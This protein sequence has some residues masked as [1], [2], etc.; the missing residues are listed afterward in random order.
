MSPANGL[1]PWTFGH[2]A[3]LLRKC[4]ILLK[5]LNAVIKQADH[6]LLQLTLRLKKCAA[7][8]LLSST[9]YACI[10]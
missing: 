6:K 2:S 7:S 4:F 8:A 1:Q 3:S 10:R 9:L 5:Q